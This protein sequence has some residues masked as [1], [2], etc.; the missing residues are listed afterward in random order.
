V[1]SEVFAKLE[2]GAT[3]DSTTVAPPE[4]TDFSPIAALLALGVIK[5]TFALAPGARIKN[6]VIN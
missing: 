6:L 5:H 2:R 4:V 3:K 1:T